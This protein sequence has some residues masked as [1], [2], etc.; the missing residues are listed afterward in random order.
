MWLT[1]IAWLFIIKIFEFF[2]LEVKHF[3][4]IWNKIVAFFAI[5]FYK[6]IIFLIYYIIII[7]I[8]KYINNIRK[9]AVIFNKRIRFMTA[10]ISIIFCRVTDNI[11]LWEYQ[12]KIEM[13]KSH[14]MD[15]IHIFLCIYTTIFILQNLIQSYRNKM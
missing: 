12:T 3:V 13:K 7:K 9:Y 5:L 2:S 15:N 8:Y 14:N 6:I 4:I 11:I 10:I 1:E